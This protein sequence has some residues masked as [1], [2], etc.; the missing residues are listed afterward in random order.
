MSQMKNPNATTYILD[1]IEFTSSLSP[2]T[3]LS[4]Q[5][6]DEAQIKSVKVGCNAGDCGACSVLLDGE[7]VC[8]CLTPLAQV[9]GRKVETLTGLMANEPLAQDLGQSFLDHGAVQCGMCTPAMLV[10]ATALHRRHLA[11]S[12]SQVKDALGGVLCRCTGYRKI[13]SAVMFR[14][15]PPQ[16]PSQVEPVGAA[17]TR[18]DGAA[19]IAAIDFGDDISETDMLE[20]RLLRSPHHH[21]SFVI[22][23]LDA[24]MQAR[25][26]LR[27]VLLAKDVPGDNCFGVIPEFAD[28]PVFAESVARFQ[29]E[30]V[31]AIVAPTAVLDSLDWNSFPIDWQPLPA[32]MDVYQALSPGAEL[33]HHHRPN[34]QMCEGRVER[35][36]LQ[37]AWRQSEATTSVEINTAFVEHAYIEPEAGMAKIVN[38]RVQV[39]GCTQ[40]PYM[41]RASLARILALQETDIQIL[42]SAVGGGF[43]AKLDLS[44]QPYVALSSLLLQQPVRMTYSRAESMSSTT[45]R[46]PAHIQV[47]AGVDAQGL[48]T[49]MEFTGTFNTGAY[50]SWGPTVANR[51]PVHAS[52]PY[53][54]PNYSAVC[55]GVHTHCVPAGAFRG[56]GVPQA[57]IAQ[58]MAF[59]QLAN[60][61]NLDRLDFRLR[62]ALDQGVATVTGQTFNGSVGIKACLAAIHLPWKK[63]LEEVE[64]RNQEAIR[65][66]SRIRFGVGVAC[67]WYGCGNTSLPNPSTIRAGISK[68]G[69]V[70]LHQ[71]A[72]DLGQGSNTVICQI[73]AQ[74]LGVAVDQV[75]LA[76]GDTDITPDAGKTS[77][78]R[79]T[80]VSGNAARLTGLELRRQIGSLLE[81]E[82]RGPLQLL[83]G[84]VQVSDVAG[85]LHHLDLRNLPDGRFG[86]AL[87]AQ[88]SYNPP[89]EALDAQGQGKP[90]AQFGYAAQMVTL[91]VD[92]DLGLVDL[93]SFVAAHD[94]GKA[95]NPVLVEGQIHGGIAQGI[96]LA[97]MEE[98]LPGHNNLHDYLLPTIGDV[99]P[100]ESIIVEVEDAHGPYGAKGL[101]E[102]VMVPTAPA[103]LGAIHH[104]TGVWIQQ[105][106]ASPE[107]ISAAI[108]SKKESFKHG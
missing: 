74:A 3:R 65:N 107:R 66:N 88:Q 72:V 51:V 42:P 76:N 83:S 99:P 37:Q 79:Q 62:N 71:G 14:P 103:I 5:L 69:Q 82:L 108:S 39:Y 86:Y 67:G 17:Y 23:D 55:R 95:I 87:A 27:M 7:P 80:F 94:V 32:S 106:P 8:A 105:L 28:Q 20:V 26:Q 64:S 70:V 101:G 13:L 85:K 46:H 61:M 59:D 38:G 60:A 68:D 40:A 34:N 18:K 100:I 35:G 1:G 33:L 31:A 63:A 2:T 41:D 89:T 104:A 98:Y 56:F 16:P 45:K 22:G 6:R 21:A 15:V 52:G 48:L 10:V 19:R 102:H 4:Q 30:A 36:D 84:G 54:W 97:L 92:L 44:F 25:P 78:S 43:G 73:F 75:Q 93:K 53:R 91:A 11:P 81:I 49:G 29:G 58:E 50:A 47:K 96:G 57:A 12:E 24:F 90:Y 9:A 77:A